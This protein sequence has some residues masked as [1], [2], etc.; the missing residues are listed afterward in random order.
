M[1]IEV[2]KS[3]VESLKE[4]S[5]QKVAWA[6]MTAID[7]IKNAGISDDENP[8]SGSDVISVASLLLSEVKQ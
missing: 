6:L 4:E 5:E 3:K 7:L 1:A 2:V 8:A